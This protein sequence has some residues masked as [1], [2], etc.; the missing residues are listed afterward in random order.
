MIESLRAKGFTYVSFD[1]ARGVSATAWRGTNRK[2]YSVYGQPS[3]DAAITALLEQIN[4]PE[5]PP[6]DDNEDLL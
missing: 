4:A 3:V 5:P 1:M 2:T 6:V